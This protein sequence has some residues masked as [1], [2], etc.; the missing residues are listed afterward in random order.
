MHPT[1]F[2]N[3]TPTRSTMLDLNPLHILLSHNGPLTLVYFKN[4]ICLFYL[5]LFMDIFAFI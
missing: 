4:Q 1:S 5:K 3:N 2:D